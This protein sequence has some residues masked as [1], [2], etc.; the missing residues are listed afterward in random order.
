[1][2]PR[3][4][5]T[6]SGAGDFF[7]I[8][9]A[10]QSFNVGSISHYSLGVVDVLEVAT[11]WM[12]TVWG[13][14]DSYAESVVNRGLTTGGVVVAVEVAL[15]GAGEVELS[16]VSSVLDARYSFI[17]SLR[18]SVAVSVPAKDSFTAA[19]WELRESKK[20]ASLFSWVSSALSN[21][22]KVSGTLNS[23]KAATR[24]VHPEAIPK[25]MLSRLCLGC[26]RIFP[27]NLR[28]LYLR[29]DYHYFSLHFVDVFSFDSQLLYWLDGVVSFFF[30]ERFERYI[31]VVHRDNEF[32]FEFYR[33]F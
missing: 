6:G 14:S 30:Q 8:Y 31:I 3:L 10:N 20:P 4:G 21:P 29:L 28:M 16:E 25:A 9:Q 19:A 2:I 24:K 13:F 18:D 12:R 1:M 11:V 5:S 26:R 23:Q 17:N 32:C 22:L 27:I 15:T 33:Q 7:G